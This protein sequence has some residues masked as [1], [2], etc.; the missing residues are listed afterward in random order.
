MRFTRSLALGLCAT[1]LAAGAVYAQQ[2][3]DQVIK[4][5]K[6][7]FEIMAHSMGILGGMARGNTPYDAAA[8]KAAADN[9]VSVTRLD[10]SSFW[11]AGSHNGTT[12]GTRAQ[13][14]IFENTADFTA[15]WQELGKRAAALQSAASNGLEALRPAIGAVGG[16]CQDCHEKYRAPAN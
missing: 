16:A 9:I 1:T 13:P 8:A 11:P 4:A 14:N 7:Q 2:N 6:G 5:R 12:K 10:Q 3:F 15:K